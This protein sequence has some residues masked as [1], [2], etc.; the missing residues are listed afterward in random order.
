MKTHNSLLITSE[1]SSSKRKV[2]AKK[3]MVTQKAAGSNCCLRAPA[4]QDTLWTVCIPTD[5]CASPYLSVKTDT[6]DLVTLLSSLVRKEIPSRYSA[7][8]PLMYILH[9]YDMFSKNSIYDN[10]LK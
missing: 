7:S 9:R 10:L 4:C 5:E 6:D 1:R 3:K 2:K 8:F